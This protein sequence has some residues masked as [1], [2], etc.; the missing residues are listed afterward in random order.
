M[1]SEGVFG[2]LWNISTSNKFT[3]HK[4][5]WALEIQQDLYALI[6]EEIKIRNTIIRVGGYKIK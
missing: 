4:I 1:K 3:Q 5:F 6:Y 2:A